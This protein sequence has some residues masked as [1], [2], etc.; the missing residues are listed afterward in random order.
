M[1]AGGGGGTAGHIYPALSVADELRA[2]GHEVAFAGTPGG[3]E[4]RLVPEAGI[5]FFPVPSR[6]YDRA[7]PLTLIAAG[8]LTFVALAR[9]LVARPNVLMLDEPSL[10]L[11]PLLVRDI[12]K[13]IVEINRRGV[14]VLLAGAAFAACYFPARWATRIDPL[15]ALRND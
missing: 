12:F 3:L 14:T 6:G 7:R 9:G 4:A 5:D 2:G 13:N 11:A 1:G 8:F 15:V 10:G